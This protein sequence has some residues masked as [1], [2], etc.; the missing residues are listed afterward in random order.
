MEAFISLYESREMVDLTAVKAAAALAQYGYSVYRNLRG[1]GGLRKILG[2]D[3]KRSIDRLV[4][5]GKRV[6]NPKDAKDC[7]NT[8]L[9]GLSA[10]SGAEME[11]KYGI[12]PMI[13]DIQAANAAVKTL[14][15]LRAKLIAGQRVYGRVIDVRSSN[16]SQNYSAFYDGDAGGAGPYRFEYD[17]TTKTTAIASVVRKLKPS[18]AYN[19][20]DWFTQLD[21]VMEVNGLNPSLSR[22]WSVLPLTFISDW[23]FNV[24]DLLESLESV[25]SPIGTDFISS[26]SVYSLKQETTVTGRGV[27][28]NAVQLATS[29]AHSSSRTTYARNTDPLTGGPVLYVPPLTLPTKASKWFSMAQI[30][31]GTLLGRTRH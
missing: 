17:K 24:G 31:F 22:V 14:S 19:D 5:I 15:D 25:S 9:T 2:R 1:G 8:L 21:I 28:A 3:A 6:M 30:A 12:K 10:L 26:D 16:G 27:V 13:S 4:T 23:F 20:V 11:W 29:S 7:W 18:A